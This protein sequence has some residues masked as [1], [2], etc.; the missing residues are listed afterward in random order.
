MGSLPKVSKKGWNQDLNPGLC[1]S[2]A[3][4]PLMTF[5]VCMSQVARIKNRVSSSQPLPTT[6]LTMMGEKP[7]QKGTR[8][9]SLEL[10]L[11]A[12]SNFPGASPFESFVSPGPRLGQGK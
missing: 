8:P 10:H 5:L 1:D 12:L 9:F 11:C 3:P 4:A 2:R 6:A 7:G